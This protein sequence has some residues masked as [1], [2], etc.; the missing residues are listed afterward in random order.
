MLRLLATDRLIPITGAS[1]TIDGGMPQRGLRF[2]SAPV[3]TWIGGGDYQVNGL[4][5]ACPGW[6][7]LRLTIATPTQSDIVTFNL[8]IE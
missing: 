7:I 5:F 6:W 4:R 8:A 3:A 1:I 2:P